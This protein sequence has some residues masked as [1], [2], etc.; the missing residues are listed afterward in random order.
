[1]VNIHIETAYKKLVP[2]K[3]INKA[4]E[5]SLTHQK[6]S[7][8]VELTVVIE[9]DE[10]LRQ[11][12]LEYLGI[13][14][15][16]DVLSFPSGDQIDPDTGVQYLGDIVISYPRAEAQA[17]ELENSI[18]DEIQLLITHGVLHLLGFDHAEETEKE[19]MW[20][21]QKEILNSLGCNITRLPE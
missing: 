3:I 17:I 21:A 7:H 14:K 2:Q 15:P 16:T 5:V 13:D 18:S 20:A 19:E 1:M 4:V 6:I 9:G 8:P 12:N 10:Q 11:L